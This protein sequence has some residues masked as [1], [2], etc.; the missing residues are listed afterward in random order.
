[1]FWLTSIGS[2]LFLYVCLEIYCL[3][4]ELIFCRV[5]A[6]QEIVNDIDGTYSSE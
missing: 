1:M 3:L 2:I 4:L 6:F 5:V